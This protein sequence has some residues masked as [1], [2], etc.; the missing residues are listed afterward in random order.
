MPK[1]YKKVFSE[2]GQRYRAIRLKK[3]KVQE[4]VTE[5]GF[6]VRHYQ[7]LEA[8]RP[9]S[10]TTLFRVAEMYKVDPCQLIKG[11]IGK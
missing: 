6:S 1:N 2:L 8:G 10:L 3:G 7:A 4:D 9:H 5:H 11:L